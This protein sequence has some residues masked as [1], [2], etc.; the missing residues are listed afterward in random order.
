M[1]QTQMHAAPALQSLILG[2]QEAGRED[3]PC[4]FALSTK[5][6]CQNHGFPSSQVQ[7]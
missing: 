4:R 6:I 7:M 2:E 1:C 5:Y 3:K